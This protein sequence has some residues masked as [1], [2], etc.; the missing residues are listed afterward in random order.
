M[1]RREF[2]A[3]STAATAGASLL[4]KPG[5]H[6]PR[7]F[8]RF[9]NDPLSFKS[10]CWPAEPYLDHAGVQRPGIQLA[11][12]QEE[13]AESV[14]DNKETY[15]VAGNMLGKDFISGFI[16]LWFFLTRDPCRV[17]LTSATADHLQVLESEM[18]RFVATSRVPI[19]EDQGGCLIRKHHN[20]T[21]TYD[22]SRPKASYVKGLVAGPDSEEALGGHHVA[23]TGDGIPRTL[24]LID[25]ASAVPD[26]HFDKARPWANR[27][28]AIGNSWDCQNFFRYA[29]EGRP[30]SDDRGGD[31]LAS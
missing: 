9:V 7:W 18:G 27:I 19:L 12:Y 13:I 24:L 31:I 11:R 28:L 20:W 3:T 26:S 16:A 1:N 2:L 22:R 10:F 4:G 5:E 23:A 17:V 15:V 25:E 30:G 6:D 14:R 8:N 29:F 21:K